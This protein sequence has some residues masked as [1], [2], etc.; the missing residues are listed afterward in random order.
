[1][2]FLSGKQFYVFTKEKTIVSPIA[3]LKVHWT[4]FEMLFWL[5]WIHHVESDLTVYKYEMKI[6]K[7]SAESG[8]LLVFVKRA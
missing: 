2:H 1:M 7:I 4:I 5:I 8:E 6:F 3:V